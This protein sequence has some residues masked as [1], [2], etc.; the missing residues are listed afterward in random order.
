VNGPP[1]Y[2][3]VSRTLV[4]AASHQAVLTAVAAWISF[5]SSSLIGL[6]E[7]YWAAI[8]SIVVAQSE[9][10]QTQVSGRDRF[11]GTAIG[12]LLALPCALYWQDRTWIFALAVGL[13]VFIC[14]LTNLNGA[15]R[16]AAVTVAV[17]VLIPRAESAWRVAL[18]RFLEVSWGIA[19]TLLLSLFVERIRQRLPSN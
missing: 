6:R 14:W 11:I 16:L 3:A 10:E 5:S 1:K 13:S 7:G 12:A 19:V 9:W 2:A 8:S 18:F 17:I 15:G 4:A